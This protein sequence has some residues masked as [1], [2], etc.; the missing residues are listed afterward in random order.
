MAAA[1][2][3]QILGITGEKQVAAIMVIAVVAGWAAVDMEMKDPMVVQTAVVTGKV[4]TKI[5]I[6]I[7]PD[8]VEE[9]QLVLVIQIPAAV[10]QVP[11]I[12]QVQWEEAEVR[13]NLLHRPT[14][15]EEARVPVLEDPV[16]APKNLAARAVLQE[17]Q[18]QLLKVNDFL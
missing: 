11:A 14:G 8:L 6:A 9:V 3:D 13:I 18:G 15:A 12:V 4:M 7:H 17:N 2:G 1:T 10:I 16:L 5:M